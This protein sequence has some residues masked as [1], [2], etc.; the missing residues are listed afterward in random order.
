MTLPVASSH[1]LATLEGKCAP[2]GTAQLRQGEEEYARSMD[3]A[4]GEAA[5]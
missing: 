1:H 5:A 4:I 2:Q 3:I